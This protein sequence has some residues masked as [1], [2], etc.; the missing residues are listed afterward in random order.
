[1]KTMLLASK[2]FTK[3]SVPPEHVKSALDDLRSATAAYSAAELKPSPS[4][5]L[6]AMTAGSVTNWRRKI[7]TATLQLTEVLTQLLPGYAAMYEKA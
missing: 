7:P 3:K 1:M 4:G 5:K 2:H 6:G